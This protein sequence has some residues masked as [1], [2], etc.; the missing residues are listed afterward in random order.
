MPPHPPAV[1]GRS[2]SDARYSPP[3]APAVDEPMRPLDA[4]GVHVSELWP[5]VS[6]QPRL[7]RTRLI[8]ERCVMRIA[9]IA[10]LY[11]DVPPRRYG[12]TERVIA[13]LCDGLVARGHDVTLFATGGSRTDARLESVISASL[14]VR[15][16]PSEMADIGGH[17]HLRMLADVYGAS[18]RLR[19]HPLPHR[20]DDA[21]V[22]RIERDADGVDVARPAGHHGRSAGL[23]HVPRRPVGVDQRP[24]TRGRRRVAGRLGGDR[25]QRPR[26]RASTTGSAAGPGSTSPSSAGSPRRSDPTWRSRSPDAPVGRCALPPRSIPSMSTTTDE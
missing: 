23:A 26:S 8:R 2:P 19:C 15:M 12:G 4:D 18:V 10:P 6:R 16:D 21:S 3:R 11:E 1:S 13:A 22:R 7:S 14:R 24:S 9:Q 20:P 17:L 5:R 25:A